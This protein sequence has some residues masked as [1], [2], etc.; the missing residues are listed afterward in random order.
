[1]NPSTLRSTGFNSTRHILGPRQF[2][3]LLQRLGPI[4]VKIG[5]YLALRPDLLPAEY[6][7]ELLDLS[8]RVPPFAWS[9]A[10]E[11]IIADLGEDPKNVFKFIEPTPSAS[12]SIAQVHIA[13]LHDGT[14]VAVK[15][16]RPHLRTT[17]TKDLR[18][19]RK[20]ARLIQ[21]TGF[22]LIAGP[23]EILDELTIWLNQEMD[24]ARELANL[25]RL[26]DLAHDDAEQRM[27]RPYPEFSG[28]RVLTEEFLH[29]MLVT[30]LLRTT[31][32]AAKGAEAV[33]TI[34]RDQLAG[35]LFRAVLKQM[36]QYQFFH[37]DLHP[38]NLVA[39]GDGSIGFVDFGLCAELDDRVR[40]H[41]LRYLSAVYEGDVNQMFDAMKDILIAGERTDMEAFRRDFLVESERWLAT[42]HTPRVQA[43]L[44]PQDSASSDYSPW[45]QYMIGVMK[46]ARRRGLSVPPRILAIYRALLTAETVSRQLSSK[47]DLPLIAKAFFRQLETNDLFRRLDPDSIQLTLIDALKLLQESPRQLN[48]VLSGLSDGT[49]AFQVEVLEATRTKKAQDRRAR[50]IV[51]SILTVGIAFLLAGTRLREMTPSLLA[52]GLIAA[53]VLLYVSVL[54]QWRK[55]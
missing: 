45:G 34:D 37:I 3:E 33:A 48:Q 18:R 1:M 7:S 21:W 16:Q 41:Q 31:G 40:Q 43:D 23:R 17:V 49:Y 20:F 51:T 35:N 27:P 52:K 11:I 44:D 32:P 26:Y 55:L 22:S 47:V 38:G 12:G 25:Q 19:L 53:L 46:A 4:S 24:F 5:Q 50:L 39:I 42:R 8:D 6:C 13:Q 28:A 10:R 54:A 15:V 2:R 29:G 9:E 30:E 14:L 36:F